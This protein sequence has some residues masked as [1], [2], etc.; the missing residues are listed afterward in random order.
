MNNFNE[1]LLTKNLQ[2]TKAVFKNNLQGYKSSQIVGRK[3]N[4]GCLLVKYQ[5]GKKLNPNVI[6]V[7]AKKGT[8]TIKKSTS[9]KSPCRSLSLNRII[10]EKDFKTEVSSHVSP[11]KILK[12]FKEKLN[13]SSQILDYLPKLEVSETVCPSTPKVIRQRKILTSKSSQ[14]LDDTCKPEK[15]SPYNQ[16]KFLT[17]TTKKREEKFDVS[18]DPEEKLKS[19][20]KMLKVKNWHEKSAKKKINPNK[21]VLSKGPRDHKTLKDIKNS[22]LDENGAKTDRDKIRKRKKKGVDLF[23]A[24]KTK[25]K[26]VNKSQDA[27]KHKSS[28]LLSFDLSRKIKRT[29]K[30]VSPTKE[31]SQKLRHLS[32]SE[33]FQIK[34]LKAKKK[35]KTRSIWLDDENKSQISRKN[36]SS[37]EKRELSIENKLLRDQLYKLKQRVFKAKKELMYKDYSLNLMTNIDKVI[38]IQRWFRKMIKDKKEESGSLDNIQVEKWMSFQKPGLNNRTSSDLVRSFDCKIFNSVVEGVK[39]YSKD[40]EIRRDKYSDEDEVESIP[41]KVEKVPSLRLNFILQAKHMSQDYNR[42]SNF[43][44]L[45]KDSLNSDSSESEIHLESNSS[46]SS[47]IKQVS[48]LDIKNESTSSLEDQPEPNPNLLTTTDYS[49]LKP[50]ENLEHSLNSSSSP[51][52]ELRKSPET[53]PGIQDSLKPSESSSD[54]SN[55]QQKDDILPLNTHEPIFIPSENPFDCQESHENSPEI[56]SGDLSYQDS[57]PESSDYSDPDNSLKRI[58]KNKSENQPEIIDRPE[59]NMIS[60]PDNSEDE[61]GPETFIFHTD[62]TISE[63]KLESLS[64]SPTQYVD[65][66]EEEAAKFIKTELDY[67]LDEVTFT[68]RQKDV[69]PGL[70]FI[71]LYIQK[72]SK[73]LEKNEDE[74]LE[75]IN[76]PSY[77]D[78]CNK[79]ET[80]QT[81]AMGKLSKFPALELILPQ[82]YSSELKE[83]FNSFETPNKQ[84]YLQMVFDCINEA[85]NHIRP[86]ALDGLPDPWSSV[87]STLYGEG[88]IKV[89]FDKIR[90]LIHKWESVK[91]GMMV[92]KVEDPSVNKVQKVQEERLNILL[93][94]GVKDFECKW[95]W[96]EDEETQVKIE[97]SDLAFEFLIEE[98]FCFIVKDV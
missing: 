81:A 70:Q 90:K 53:Q 11:P 54:D 39:D 30:L 19:S 91:C 24:L 20:V 98:T 28:H 50:E 79:L 74:M 72:L 42:T 60:D 14:V 61:M 87:S 35:K 59:H 49:Q 38:K 44:H 29:K 41:K 97:V 64:V 3:I 7:H 13:G 4:N 76:T 95:L 34:K 69:D 63:D 15:L 47:K 22:E 58:L 6:V 86:F 31:E 85:L 1:N 88:Q 40:E 9:K 93:A 62:T 45:I 52:K 33:K 17:K 8:D 96:Y 65:D 26:K 2:I 89:V 37:D 92:D 66:F 56:L 5:K 23:S 67:F 68:L 84:I 71:D 48:D 83:D 75:L 43:G 12:K 57:E 51:S 46:S 18:R 55:T 25:P 36:Q 21:I 82:H 16:N 32:S 10:G 77:Q 94:Q 27:S 80:L 78:P 73:K